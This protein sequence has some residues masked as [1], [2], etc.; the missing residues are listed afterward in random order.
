MKTDPYWLIFRQEFED[1]AKKSKTKFLNLSNKG[2]LLKG[3][4]FQPKDLIRSQLHYLKTKQ[5]VK[6]SDHLYY[7]DSEA[8]E[9]LKNLS[10][11]LEKMIGQLEKSQKKN[12]ELQKLALT[13]DSMTSKFFEAVFRNSWAI[14]DFKSDQGLAFEVE[15]LEFDQQLLEL[16]LV[17][18][19]ALCSASKL[20][21]STD[22]L[23]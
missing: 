9:D 22:R 10:K 7:R 8:R 1:I 2:L 4:P 3:I 16:F 14:M 11:K 17:C 19:E 21:K 13:S 6:I 12:L 18:E 20:L 23:F 15:K 5:M